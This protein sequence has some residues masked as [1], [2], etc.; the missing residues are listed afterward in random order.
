[1]LT[2]DSE[3][4]KSPKKY[5]SQEIEDIKVKGEST[6]KGECEKCSSLQSFPHP[7]V[8]KAART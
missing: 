6:K 3:N 5:Y 2:A 4:S 1:M 7:V 8:V